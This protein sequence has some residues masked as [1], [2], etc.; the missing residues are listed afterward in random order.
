MFLWVPLTVAPELYLDE[1]LIH[2]DETL[3][4][5]LFQCL[6]LSTSNLFYIY[7]VPNFI[8]P[9]V[10]SNVTELSTRI[11]WTLLIFFMLNR[12]IVIEILKLFVIN[13]ENISMHLWCILLM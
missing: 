1:P 7:Q 10:E 6:E 3:L 4:L 11:S 5:N 12:V 13:L 2:A 8:M 9:T